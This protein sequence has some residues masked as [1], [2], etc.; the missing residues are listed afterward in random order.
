[1]VKLGK[2]PEHIAI[3]MDGNR[4]Y[5]ERL[6]FSR[7]KGHELGKNKVEQVLDW[8]LDLDIRILTVYALST[9]NLKREP[10]EVDELM[11]LF[12]KGFR[13]AAD[14]ERV[15]KYKIKIKALGQT[16]LLSM[17]VQDAIK[18]AENKTKDYSDYYYNIAIAYGSREE[19][20]HAIQ[21]IAEDAKSG[22]IDIADIDDEMVS[23]YLYTKEFPD[24]ELVLRTSGE[25][26]VSN[27]LLWQL[28]YSELYFTDV[29]WPGFRRID[30]L[31]ALRTYQKREKRYDTI[32]LGNG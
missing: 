19:I 16:K 15:H 28:A 27:F 25:V 24:P 21:K 6:G 5:A 23:S 8:C 22:K 12:V 11:E 29:F 7:K 26:R 9:E 31:R 3:I 4:R 1:M 10:S 18:Y 32:T 14:D 20:T 17:K 30:F 2:K 13:D